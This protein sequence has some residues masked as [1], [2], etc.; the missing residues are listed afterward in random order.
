MSKGKWKPKEVTVEADGIIKT[1]IECELG[2]VNTLNEDV[3]IPGVPKEQTKYAA[4][5]VIQEPNPGLLMA[6]VNNFC[7]NL[8]Y[9]C[10]GGVSVTTWLSANGQEFL[11]CQAMKRE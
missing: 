1:P 8:G 4:Y 3:V 7:M 11:Y 6:R 9:Q 2:E 10:Q 5:V